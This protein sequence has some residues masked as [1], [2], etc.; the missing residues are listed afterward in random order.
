MNNQE[1][2]KE[3]QKTLNDYVSV[4]HNTATK[5]SVDYADKDWA[6]LS[7]DMQYLATLATAAERATKLLAL[8]EIV[9]LVVPENI[10]ESF[11]D[12][13]APESPGMF[14]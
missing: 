12:E 11:A 10:T 6:E 2:I 14:L 7:F 8:S 4:I 9:D 5:L 3:I 13:V 1:S